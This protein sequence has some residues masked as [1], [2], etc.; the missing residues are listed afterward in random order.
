MEA[1]RQ[2]EGGRNIGRLPPVG[3]LL[4]ALTVDR[5][6]NLG[7]CSDREVNPRPSGVQDDVPT[8]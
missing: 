1:E 2:R 7:M 4:W 3:A 5:T 6:R 8:D